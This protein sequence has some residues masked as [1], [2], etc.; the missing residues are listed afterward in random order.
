MSA[1]RKATMQAYK[2]LHVTSNTFVHPSLQ[3]HVLTFT[4]YQLLSVLR[5]TLK[6]GDLDSCMNM[7]IDVRKFHA[8]NPPLD[9]RVK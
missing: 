7:L 3:V 1:H 8:T 4:V 6:S 9:R 5:P 2:Q